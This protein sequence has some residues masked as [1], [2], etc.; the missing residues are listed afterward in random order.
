MSEYSKDLGVVHIS[1]D[2]IA[3]IAAIAASEV[4]GVHSLS[5]GARADL[6]GK[7]NIAKGVKIT[8]EN[9]NVTCYLFILVK[10]DCPILDVS[11]AVQEN[12]KSHIESMTGLHVA[13]VN[14]NVAGVAFGKTE[15]KA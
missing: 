10:R 4:E 6:R 13:A 1:H 15:R 5:T 12:V 7:R 8:I 11:K 9:G 3:S 2:V 14:V